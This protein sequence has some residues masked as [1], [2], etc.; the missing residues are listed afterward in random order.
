M[1]TR[2]RT[3]RRRNNPWVSPRELDVQGWWWE[4]ICRMM[5]QA[6]PQRG[7][8]V[9]RFILCTFFSTALCVKLSKIEWMK[10]FFSF[11]FQHAFQKCTNDGDDL[12][13]KLLVH[14]GCSPPLLH[15]H[16]HTCIYLQV[17]PIYVHIHNIYI[18]VIHKCLETFTNWRGA[19]AS[20][21][22]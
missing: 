2:R 12:Q 16:T 3:R 14:N 7:L 21:T 13:I 20:L 15:T 4:I 17:F 1:R 6:W 5:R 9:R 8:S 10:L 18:D 19:R 22:R 11:N